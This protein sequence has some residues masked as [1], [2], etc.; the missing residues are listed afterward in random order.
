[1]RA[2]DW[3]FECEFL[4]FTRWITFAS[5]FKQALG[6]WASLINFIHSGMCDFTST[7]V[8]PGD[9]ERDSGAVS[10]RPLH[11]GP[12]TQRDGQVSG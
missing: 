5:P 2:V 10:A 7:I 12:S 3:C 1:M 8:Q 6:L 11:A 9:E 4:R